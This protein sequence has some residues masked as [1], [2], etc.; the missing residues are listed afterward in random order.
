MFLFTQLLGSSSLAVAHWQYLLFAFEGRA[1]EFMVLPFGLSLAPRTFTKRMDAVLA[2]LT[3]RGL[4]SLNYL[5]DWLICAP[6]RTQVLSDRD[7]LL[8]HIGGLGITVNGKSRLTPTQRV[9]FIGMETQ[10]S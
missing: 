10:S 2:P 9:A 1:Y 4:L 8:T 3:S 6:T 5:D 7:M